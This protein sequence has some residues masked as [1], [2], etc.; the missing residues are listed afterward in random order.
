[1][2]E[3]LVSYRTYVS[4]VMIMKAST[5]CVVLNDLSDFRI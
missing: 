3:V 2:A 5:S 1:M 4:L